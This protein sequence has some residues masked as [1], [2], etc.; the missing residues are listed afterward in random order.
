M[1]VAFHQCLHSFTD[2]QYTEDQWDSTFTRPPI[3]LFHSI[4]QYCVMKKGNLFPM[5]EMG[6]GLDVYLR[7]TLNIAQYPGGTQ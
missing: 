2:F 4:L 1:F 7:Y 5:N 3:H 6:L